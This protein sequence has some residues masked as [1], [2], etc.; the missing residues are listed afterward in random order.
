MK[1]TKR[2]MAAAL[3]FA[4]ASLVMGCAK[5]HVLTQRDCDALTS[6]A[7]EC[8]QTNVEKAMKAWCTANLGKT[9]DKDN[10][11]YNSQ[12][13]LAETCPRLLGRVASFNRLRGS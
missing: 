2:A 12:G 10:W 7:K 1:N 13:Y 11:E 8:Q 9:L 4:G 5:T 3:L 6:K